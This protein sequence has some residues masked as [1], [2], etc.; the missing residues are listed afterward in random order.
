MLK[1]PSP[2]PA[3]IFVCTKKR[4]A[5]HPKSCCHDRGASELR[6][7]LKDMVKDEGLEGQVRVFKSGCLGVCEQGPA[8]IA[9]PDGDLM[10]AIEPDDLPGI[11]E[12]AR[13]HCESKSGN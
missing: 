4:E 1:F 9:Y 7:K 6:D 8:A 11:L 10:M 13:T 5:G 3:T 12:A 2:F